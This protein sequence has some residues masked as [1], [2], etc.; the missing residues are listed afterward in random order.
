MLSKTSETPTAPPSSNHAA[1]TEPL[2]PDPHVI[3]EL[4]SNGT[5]TPNDGSATDKPPGA[6]ESGDSAACL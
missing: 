6:C 3:I 2:T 5:G 4:A 1:R